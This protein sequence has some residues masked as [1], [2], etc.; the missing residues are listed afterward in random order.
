MAE[1]LK[2][3]FG[4]E[5]PK[6]I[7]GMI[8][9]VFPRFDAQAFL[10]E[11]FKG[12]EDLH[13]TPRGWQIARAL[14]RHLPDD[15]AAAADIL[16]ASL[17]PKLDRTEG[18]GMAPFLYLPHVLF[19]AE[20]GLDHFELSMRAQYELTQRFTA[21]FG[22][23]PFLVRYPEQTLARLTAWTGD[24][25]VHV[26]RLV[27]EGTRPRLPWAPRLRA[28]QAN[29]RPVLALL[30]RLKDDP[31]LYVCRSVANNLNDIGKDHPA[32]QRVKWVSVNES[33]SVLKPLGITGVKGGVFFV[34]DTNLTQGAVSGRSH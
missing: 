11:A 4:P 22:I 21:E 6:R 25:S 18:L 10:D 32:L 29:P 28:F 1:P 20:Y 27:S 14:R 8:S 17:G 16:I 2:N 26:R 24:P 34:P 31:E 23:R 5:I 33:R 19:V 3:H 13:L 7:A 15:F 30:E 12:Y 9:A